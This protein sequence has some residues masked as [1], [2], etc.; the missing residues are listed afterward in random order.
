VTPRTGRD[1]GCHARR[2]VLKRLFATQERGVA[3]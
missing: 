1:A 3:P 2:T